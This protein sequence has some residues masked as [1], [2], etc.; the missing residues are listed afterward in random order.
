MGEAIEIKD[1]ISGK[2]NVGLSS[3]FMRT[4]LD[5]TVIAIDLLDSQKE[6]LINMANLVYSLTP[7][8]SRGIP[9]WLDLV[10]EEVKISDRLLEALMETYL[11]RDIYEKFFIPTRSKRKGR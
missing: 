3:M 7:E 11:D 9:L 10:D 2:E 4:S 5:P 8:N 6:E 1:N